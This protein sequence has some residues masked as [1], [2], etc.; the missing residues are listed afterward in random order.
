MSTNDDLAAIATGIPADVRR[1]DVLSAAL[2]YQEAR[3]SLVPISDDGTK[4]P[5][6]RLLP[7]IWDPQENRW[8]AMW[9][10]FQFRRP[11]PEQLVEWF[12]SAN[13]FLPGIGVVCGAVSGG[14]E[15]IDFD[16]IA[17]CQ[18]WQELVEERQPGL[19]ERL[20]R[21]HTPRPGM[22]LYYRCAVSGSEE[23]LACAMEMPA[24]AES[25]Q[26]VR[27]RALIEKKGDGCYCLAPPSPR[28]CHPTGDLYEYAP[29]S[30]TLAHLPTISPAERQI[31]LQAARLLDQCP[32]EPEQAPAKGEPASLLARG[33]RPG[34]EYNRRTTWEEL[35]IRHGWVTAGGSGVVTHWRRPGKNEGISATTNYRG[36]DLLYVFSSNASPFEADRGYTK[37]AALA[38]LEHNGDFKAAA[39]AVRQQRVKATQATPHQEIV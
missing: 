28:R 31:L 3:I 1:E 26:Q 20:V 15:V 34:D 23:D 21:I 4:S 35:L 39:R 24:T 14:L 19:I 11:T 5:S 22:H 6:P 8:R 13:G 36:S 33:N 30:P 12:G 10:P 7:Q 25:S 27:R 38:L 37:F 9:K 2:A 29:D 18:P 32:D 17:S 16:D